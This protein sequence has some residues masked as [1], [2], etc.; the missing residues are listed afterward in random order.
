MFD[1]VALGFQ[2]EVQHKPL[3]SGFTIEI[4]IGILHITV[5]KIV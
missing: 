5:P 4:R 1:V 3:P 2:D